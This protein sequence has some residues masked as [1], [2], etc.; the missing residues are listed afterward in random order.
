MNTEVSSDILIERKGNSLP[1]IK[2]QLSQ[3]NVGELK[4]LITVIELA[5]DGAKAKGHERWMHELHRDAK[6]L[7]RRA[8]RMEVR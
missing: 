1:A 2:L 5:C 8:E 4:T 7:R 3:F 6:R